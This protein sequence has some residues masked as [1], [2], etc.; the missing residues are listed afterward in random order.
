[1][2]EQGPIICTV[3]GAAVALWCSG[4]IGASSALPLAAW[5]L[6]AAVPPAV[7]VAAVVV[8]AAAPAAKAAVGAVAAATLC[9]GHMQY[10]GHRDI[11]TLLPSVVATLRSNFQPAHGTS[12]L[13]PCAAAAAAAAAAAK[14]KTRLKQLNEKNDRKKDFLNFFGIF[15]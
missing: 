13:M 8:A 12:N 5:A 1:V 3:L 2:A 9:N 11:H 7:G 6:A 10:L 4:S 15:F 14:K